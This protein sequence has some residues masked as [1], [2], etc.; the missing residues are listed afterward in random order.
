MCLKNRQTDFLKTGVFCQALVINGGNEVWDEMGNL[1]SDNGSTR[2]QAMVQFPSELAVGKN[3][4]P[5]TNKS[6]LGFQ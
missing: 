3:G 1:I 5:P 2:S 6:P 4:D